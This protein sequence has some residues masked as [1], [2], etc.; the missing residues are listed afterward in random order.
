MILLLAEGGIT[1]TLGIQ[2][3]NSMYL[4][5][6]PVMY[7]LFRLLLLVPGHAP[8]WTRNLSM[9][10]YVIH[11]AVLIALRGLAEAAGLTWLLTDNTMMQFLTV[12]AVS[13][14]AAAL[15]GYVT[16]SILKRRR[17]E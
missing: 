13:F 2:R 15:I 14:A 4:F 17:R 6:I 11:P 16:G 1:Y 12:T 5:L 9:L 3:H 8:V 10:V 7:F